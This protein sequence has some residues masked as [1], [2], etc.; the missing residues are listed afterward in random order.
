VKFRALATLE[1]ANLA[2]NKDKES[3]ERPRR[4]LQPVDYDLMDPVEFIT[5]LAIEDR[6]EFYFQ[7]TV[8]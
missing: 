4:I 2:E 6:Q 3:R 1:C 8:L 7:L 5:K